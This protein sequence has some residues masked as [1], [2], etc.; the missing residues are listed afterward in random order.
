MAG[1]DRPETCTLSQAT[2][3]FPSIITGGLRLPESETFGEGKRLSL[4]GPGRDPT[5]RR[6]PAQTSLVQT[7]GRC[8]HQHGWL[9]NVASFTGSARLWKESATGWRVQDCS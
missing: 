2:Y 1:V 9:G 6:E 8:S 5:A 4:E 7:Q 3:Q